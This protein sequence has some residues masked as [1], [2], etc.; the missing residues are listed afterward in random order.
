MAPSFKGPR[1]YLNWG[2]ANYELARRASQV[3]ARPLKL[4]FDPTNAC[5]LKCPLCP[6]GLRIHDRTL[7]RA[8]VQ[9]FQELMDSIGDYVFFLD[10][11]NWGEPLLNPNLEELIRIASDKKI[12]TSISSNL[13]LELSDERI[14]QLVTSGLG[15]LIVSLDGTDQETY[16]IYRREGD[17][18]LAFNNMRR[19]V[20]VKRKLGLSRPLV[21]W[22]FLVFRFN[23]HQVERAHEMAA[24]IGV[25]AL[26]CRPPYLE[27]DQFPLSDEDRAAVENWAPKA[28][29]FNRYDPTSNH[30]TE[31]V[32][33]GKRPRCGWHYMSTAIN[34]DGSVAPCCTLHE[35]QHD[36]GNMNSAGGGATYMEVV[37][38]DNF[39]AV[40]DRFAGRRKEETG[41]ICEKCPTPAIM[42]YHHHLNKQIVLFTLVQA[43]EGVRRIFRPKR[44]PRPAPALAD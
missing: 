2:R 9:Q 4:T 7:G 37:N 41:L 18:E 25:D 3:R 44:T 33:V 12:A 16:E 19:I 1:A 42:S 11:F 34:W 40:R 36:F 43:V 27:A 17:F 26:T 13:S 14:H 20:E 28:P 35:K 15:Q 29:E 38:N 30:Y 8:P 24:E 5:Q 32:S 23:E 10:L 22:Q 31:E 21:N 39:R 6:T